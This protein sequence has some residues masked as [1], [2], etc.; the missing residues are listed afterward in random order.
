M[1]GSQIRSWLRFVVATAAIYHSAMPQ[2]HRNFR[3]SLNRKLRRAGVATLNGTLNNRA[4][5]GLLGWINGQTGLI[6]SVFVAY[7]A[8]AEYASYYFTRKT[9]D[10]ARW[11]PVLCGV[12]RQNAKLTVG[13]GITSTEEDFRG[14]NAHEDL[15]D[16]ATRTAEIARTLRVSQ[17][18]Y[19]GVLPG[20]MHRRGIV[21]DPI[22]AEVTAAVMRRSIRQLEALESLPPDV[23]LIVLGAKGF[24]GAALCAAL[25]DRE[26]WGVDVGDPW[27]SHLAGEQAI[28]VNVSNRKAL[29]LF[30]DRLWPEI[31]L[32]NEV[33]PEPSRTQ[34]RHLHEAGIAAYHVVGVEA[35]VLPSM[36]KAYS[37]GIPCCA[38]WPAED[39]TPIVRRLEP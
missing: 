30:I 17:A 34:R 5:L 29:D 1:G 13:F 18:T 38:A 9:F 20:L 28:L 10:R 39:L 15:T 22:E 33:Y 4:F 32:L 8:S 7:P 16:L 27:P 6:A 26:V 19:S 36:P 2:R 35:F 25:H 21:T 31:I 12:I 23:P 24:V 37:G 11:Q 3:S 14:P